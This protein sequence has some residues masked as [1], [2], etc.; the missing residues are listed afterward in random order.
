MTSQADTLRYTDLTLLLHR[1]E[2]ILFNNFISVRR[3]RWL[4]VYVLFYTQVQR[5]LIS[6]ETL[7]T[8]ERVNAID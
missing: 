1:L 5:E 8:N 6:D 7:L 2:A 3:C 4:Y